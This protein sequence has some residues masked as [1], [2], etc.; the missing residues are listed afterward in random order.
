MISKH[1]CTLKFTVTSD[2]QFLQLHQTTALMLESIIYYFHLSIHPPSS[3]LGCAG[4]SAIFREFW[5]YL[6]WSL[7]NWAFPESFPKKALKRNPNQKLQP[8]QLDAKE[9]HLYPK[10]P[11]NIRV[12]KLSH[13]TAETHWPH[14]S[15]LSS[16]P[17]QQSSVTHTLLWFQQRSWNKI[18]R[19]SNSALGSNLEI[20]ITSNKS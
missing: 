15:T 1:L 14:S 11:P 9:Q 13:P 18:Q 6:G 5:V 2:D 8:P 19:Y 4:R 10:L 3:K 20:H 16:G 17:S 7:S 12:S